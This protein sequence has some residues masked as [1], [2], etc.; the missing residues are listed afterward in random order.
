MLQY[1][2]RRIL[3]FI[4]VVLGV[5]TIVFITLRSIPGDPAA[6]FVGPDGTLADRQRVTEA[7]GLDK[8]VAVQYGIYVWRALQ[9]DFG[10]SIF[11]RT[12]VSE[13]VRQTFPATLELAVLAMLAT[14]A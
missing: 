8:P 12:E 7:M 4:P 6:V 11:L 3:M 2:A 14:V 13:L 9:G 5:L 10:R 1:A